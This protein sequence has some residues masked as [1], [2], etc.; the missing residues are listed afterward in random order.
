MA[1]SRMLRLFQACRRLQ[2]RLTETL[3]ARLRDRGYPGVTAGHL[4]FLAELECG[5]NHAAEI[6]RR[7]GISRQAVHKQVKELAALG[8]LAERPDARRRNRRTIVFTDPG[9][10]MIADARAILAE[11]DAELPSAAGRA[12]AEDAAAFLDEAAARF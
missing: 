1:D 6:A 10:Q 9:V 7:T 8:L 11:M 2:E 4:T 3:V 12:T 5:E